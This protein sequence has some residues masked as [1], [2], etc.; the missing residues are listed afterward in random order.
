MT[1][2]LQHGSQPHLL[3]HVEPVVARRAV[4]AK[5]DGDAFRPHLGDRRDARSELEIRAGTMHHFDVVLGEQR[6]LRV[7]GPHAV[8]DTQTRRGEPNIREILELFSPPES[9]RTI[10]ISSRDS[11]A[12]VCTSAC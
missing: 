3:E 11:D 1:N 2:R 8:R 10:A 7:V 6:L 9:S 5:R 4:G 12:C